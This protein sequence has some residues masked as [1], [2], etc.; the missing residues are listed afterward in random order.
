MKADEL[1]HGPWWLRWF[2]SSRDE[3]TLEEIR[4]GVADCREY[5]KVNSNFALHAY[6]HWHRHISWNA[7]LPSR[8]LWKKCSRSFPG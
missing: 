4:K 1:Y 2:Y 8:L 6:P 3:K 7:K 5:F